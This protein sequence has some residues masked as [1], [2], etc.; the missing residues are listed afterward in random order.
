[1]QDVPAGA[2]EPQVVR[3]CRRA[4]EHCLNV[5]DREAAENE[6]GAERRRVFGRRGGYCDVLGG[7]EHLRSGG[8]NLRT[9]NVRID[10]KC[11]LDFRFS[12]CSETCMFSFGYFPGVRLSLPTFRNLL[13][14][15]SSKAG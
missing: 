10:K 7:G 4:T 3:N 8:S 14:G 13:S 1:V 6:E 12:P 15:P 9:S 5:L 11:I 2:G